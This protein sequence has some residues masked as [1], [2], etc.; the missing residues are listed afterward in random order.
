M[1]GSLVVTKIQAIKHKLL[2]H[3]GALV[4]GLAY[5]VEERDTWPLLLLDRERDLVR[6]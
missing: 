3:D 4:I 5:P 1:M 2:V 6:A